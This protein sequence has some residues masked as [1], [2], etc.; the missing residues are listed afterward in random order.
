VV[1]EKGMAVSFIN[2]LFD[3]FGSGI[4]TSKTGIVLHN[5]GKGFVTDPNHRNCIAPGKRPLHTLVPA[6][7]LKEGKP[8]MAFGVMGA[9]F[10]PM[11][12]VYVMSNMFEH[13]MDAQEA[14]D[15]PRVF[16]EEDVLQ[17]E[18]TVPEEVVSGL[19]KLGH[20]VERRAVP[21]G[22]GQIVIMDRENGVLIGASDPRKDGMAIGY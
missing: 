4:V 13:G 16:F 19:K 22:G 6:M 21:W 5:R 15:A 8:H 12:H 3:E 2:S 9:H 18:Q 20:R 17:V 10:Q 14:L 7:V 1:D 11:G